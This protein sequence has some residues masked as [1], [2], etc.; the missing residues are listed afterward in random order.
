MNK[1]AIMTSASNIRRAPMKVEDLQVWRHGDFPMPDWVRRHIAEDIETNGTFLLKT[2]LG[3]A[4]VHV[5]HAVIERK[6]TAYT[7]PLSEVKQLL[8]ELAE[9]EAEVPPVTGS[10][11]GPVAEAD[12]ADRTDDTDEISRKIS[13]QQPPRFASGPEVAAEQVAARVAAA[14]VEGRTANPAPAPRALPALAKL[15]QFDAP[16]GSMPSIEW[17]QLDRLKVDDSYQRS[18]ENEASRKLIVAIATSWDWRLCMPLAVSKREDGFYVIDGQH[19]L[20]AA[21]LRDD[22]PQ[23]PCCVSR[24]EDAADEAKMFVAANRSKRMIN[25][26]DEFHAALVAGDQDIVAINRIIVASSLKVSRKTGAQT[27]VPGE[28]TFTS[29]IGAVLRKHGEKTCRLALTAI[30]EAFPDEVLSNGASVFTALTKIM[31][32]PPPGFDQAQ[33]FR[34]LKTFN[35]KQWGDF[36]QGIKGGERRAAAMRQIMLEAYDDIGV[37]PT[38]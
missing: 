37:E 23:L 13:A 11:H 32:T 1:G 14:K 4:R 28:V 3:H 38:C 27:W 2:P 10:G 31:V 29:A 26:L 33:L 17:V 22:I 15:K 18:I 21:M 12:V 30:A 35:M 5:G 16:I 6:G 7:R 24:Y 9:E 36:V 8:A 19:R 34:A 20:S 25:R